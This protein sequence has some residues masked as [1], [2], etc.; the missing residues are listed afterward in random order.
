M[1][2]ALAFGPA[3]S[4]DATEA[5]D[6][7]LP[8]HPREGSSARCPASARNS[9]PRHAGRSEARSHLHD[10]A[11]QEAVWQASSRS[12]ASICPPQH[13]EQPGLS[14]DPIASERKSMT[15]QAAASWVAVPTLDD[16]NDQ[17]H[18][19]D[20]DADVDL[21]RET[22]RNMPHSAAPQRS[23]ASLDNS[24]GG[25]R[26]MSISYHAVARRD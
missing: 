24:R 20:H 8:L 21:R 26:I 2:P 7:L 15:R 9:S 19:A 23:R 13:L 1:P 10:R 11:G 3:A 17:H 18:R 14:E 6:P 4:F 16:R 12:P 25:S 5:G 22:E